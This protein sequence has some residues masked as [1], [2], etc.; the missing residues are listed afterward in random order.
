MH[1][2]KRHEEYKMNQKYFPLSYVV[3][4]NLEYKI[5]DDQYHNKNKTIR[6]VF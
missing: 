6:W 5:L 4:I 1:A 2:V 3:I